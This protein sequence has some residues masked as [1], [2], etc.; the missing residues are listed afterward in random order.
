MS[1]RLILLAAAV[2]AGPAAVAAQTPV[3]QL[4]VTAS[5]LGQNPAVSPYSIAVV[6]QAYLAARTS[7][8][9]ALG[10]LSDIYV[11][12]PGGRAGASSIFLR[13]ADPNFTAVLF[14]GVQLNDPTNTRGG[15][16]NVSEIGSAGLERIEVVSGALSGLYGSGALAGAVNLVVPGGAEKAQ[17]AVT[18]GAG[19]RDFWSA[20]ATVR[21]PLAMG[22]GGSLG[23]ATD[24]DGEQT[25]G[26]HFRSR[27]LTAKVAPL[28]AEDAGRLI[29]RLG[30]RNARTFPDSS[31]GPRLAVRHG[32][33]VRKSR[34]QLAGLSLPVYRG[35]TS[36]LDLS[37]SILHRRDDTTSVGV[38]PSVFNPSGVPAGE[39]HTHYTRATASAV[40]RV[41][42]GAWKLAAGGEFL[43]EDGRNAGML[44]FGFFSAP[45]SFDLSRDT[46]SGFVEADRSADALSLNAGL[47]VDDVEGLAARVTGRAGARY[48]LGSGLSLKAAAA[49]GFKAPSFYA[50]ANPFVGNRNLKPETSKSGELGLAWAG[51]PGAAAS[52][53][54]F[55]SRYKDLIDFI[56]GPPPRL[57]NRNLVVSKGV[58]AAVTHALSETVTG[59]LQVQ[60]AQTED[61]ATGQQLLNR[62]RWR[63]NAAVTWTPTDDLSFAVRHAYVG[64]RD[65]FATPVGSQTMAGYNAVSVEAAWTFLPA[66]TARIVIDNALDDDHEDALGF[67]A[68]GLG[69]RLYL[70]RSF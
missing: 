15:A 70:N 17:G 3:D 1:L 56:P 62:P 6:P 55:Y 25:P 60:Y 29:V 23:L 48:D 13:G 44:N 28:G 51:A 39:D 11:Q 66:T 52:V 43:R 69:A 12:A 27:T 64:D 49:T 10:G 45:N 31:G 35:E 30:E 61:D 37:G 57:E 67:P 20:A 9:D 34:D 46:V 41:T 16:V 65:D 18:L 21:G 38:A 63:V 24:D 33:D 36:R 14:D 5:R 54:L 19:T 22:L 7:V 47:R 32:V 58:S 8:A 59:S 4:V 68:P 26:S 50:L 53:T 40:S 2:A 42:V